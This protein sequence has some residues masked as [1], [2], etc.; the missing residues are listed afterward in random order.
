MFHLIGKQ[1]KKDAITQNLDH[2][3]YKKFSKRTKKTVLNFPLDIINRTTESMPKRID[4]V[5]K[6]KG[7]RTKY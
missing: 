4:Q 1:L 7:Q 3:T 5:I 2:E 6:M